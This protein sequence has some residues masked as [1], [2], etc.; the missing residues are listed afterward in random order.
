VHQSIIL[1]WDSS[2]QRSGIPR[3]QLLQLPDK[4]HQLKELFSE[5]KM[6]QSFFDAKHYTENN[7]ISYLNHCSSFPYKCTIHIQ[8]S[9]PLSMP[10]TTSEE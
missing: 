9:S 4:H 5:L 2:N 1:G 3:D 6:H 8:K 7:Q 10:A